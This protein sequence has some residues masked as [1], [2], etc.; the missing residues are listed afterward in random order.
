M[1]IELTISIHELCCQFSN[2]SAQNIIDKLAL[3]PLEHEGGWVKEFGLCPS[4]G[5]SSIYYLLKAGD[6]TSW[7]SVGAD[8]Y[9]F[10]HS[11]ANIRFDRY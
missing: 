8:E 6:V 5:S 10:H 9:W 2:M 4:G 11:G 1:N 3:V 7:H